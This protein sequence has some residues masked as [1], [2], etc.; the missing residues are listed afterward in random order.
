MNDM[1]TNRASEANKWVGTWA[2]SPYFVTPDNMPPSPGLADNTLRQVIRVSIKGD[3][4]RLKFS[5]QYGEAPLIMK[6]VH[7]AYSE[8]GHS[9]NTATTNSYL[10]EGNAAT[11]E[12]MSES[13]PV[14]RW[15]VITGIDVL[16]DASYCSVV[17]LGDSITDGRGT[18][19]DKNNRWTDIL[20]N[21]LQANSTTAKIGVLNM[22][23]GG[24][25]LVAGGL[26]PAAALRFDRDVLGHSGVRYLIVLEGV[27]DLGSHFASEETVDKMINTY[28]EFIKKAHEN[29]ILVYGGTVTPFGTSF[30]DNG[31]HMELRQKVNDWIRTSGEFD[32]VID[33][34]EAVTNKEQPGT[35]V[36]LY[37]SGDHLHLSP[38]GYQ[39]MGKSISLELFTK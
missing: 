17:A 36:A 7:L 38:E 18:T 9:V 5:N 30:Y 8:G 1:N 32:A 26:G 23:I 3:K 11:E 16:T 20:A 33:F 21:R 29:N 39:R 25:A 24:N 12:S 13:I 4:I 19:T 10:L 34:D 14:E 27:N 15:Y 31:C 28:R 2:A 6:S 35:L 22:G 37:D